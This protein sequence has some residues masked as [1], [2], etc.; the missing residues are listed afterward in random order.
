[1]ALTYG[2]LNLSAPFGGWFPLTVARL[3][4]M[5]FWSKV[6]L[7]TARPLG[8]LLWLEIVLAYVRENTHFMEIKTL[9]STVIQVFYYKISRFK[10]FWGG[11]FHK[12]RIILFTTEL[13][14]FQKV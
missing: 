3:E 6:T 11:K 14:I 9:F 12:F 1:M 10:K 8:R 4:L 5:T 13:R 7:S 2:E